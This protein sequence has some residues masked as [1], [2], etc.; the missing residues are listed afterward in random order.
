MHSGKKLGKSR[1]S[2]SST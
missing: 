1:L 2:L